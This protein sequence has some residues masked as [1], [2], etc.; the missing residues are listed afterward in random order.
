MQNLKLFSL[1]QFFLRRTIMA[2]QFS[3]KDGKRWKAPFFTIWGGQAL[4]LLGS[5]LVQFALIWYL[6]VETN[7][8]T[9]LATASLVGLVPQVV[10]GPI[11]GTLVDRWNR[12]AIMIIADSI[13]ALATVVL[14]VLFALNQI[15]IWHIYLLMFIRSLAGGFHGT[16]MTA[17]TSLMV[18]KEHLTRI[19]GINQMLN[20]GLNIVAAPLGA[21]LLEL[22][23]MQ[24][25][26]AIDV[27]TALLAITPLFFLVIPQPERIE[28]GQLAG[29]EKPSIWQDF[30][31]G[32]RYMLGWP[33]L[34]IIAMMAVFIN[35]L[36]TPAFSLL[37]LLVKD[38]FNGAA[39]QLGWVNS[40]FGVGI[41][42]GG[43]LLGVWG[44]FKRKIMTSMF[45]LIGMGVGTLLMSQVPPTGI[46][47]A[48]GAALI[49]GIM[50]PI[51]NGPIFAVMQSNVAPDMQ[52][53]VFSLL[54]SMAA[55]MSP[56]GLIIAGPISDK[57]GIQTWF[58]LGGSI[59]ILMALVGL[60]IP[61]LMNIEA[62]RTNVSNAIP[63]EP[64]PELSLGD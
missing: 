45:G 28:Q 48:V 22:L 46:Y 64:E 5:Q 19:Q 62:E 61:A 13:I 1:H 9:V 55:G 25:I 4:S 32:L 7:S 51:T 47:I 60:F 39:I 11:V 21:L 52:A 27:V 41:I 18:P 24:G 43:L 15:E 16:S 49:V 3:V 42:L 33:G 6:T 54:N 36:L 12:R 2:T 63:G 40:A 44:G 20:G 34:L 50:Q 14:A 37:P 38:Y 53:R 35:F 8:A 26:L 58:L 17:S 30:L 23:P 31:S 57:L 56:I 59:C 29:K 10:L